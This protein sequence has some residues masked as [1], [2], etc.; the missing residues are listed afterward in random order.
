MIRIGLIPDLRQGRGGPTSF[1]TRFA[2]SLND[3][4]GITYEFGF[5][6]RKF[7]AILLINGTRW[8]HKLFRAKRNGATIVHRLGAP[9][10]SNESANPGLITRL[11]IA[12]GMSNVVFLR[13]YLADHIVYQS[14]FVSNAWV[15]RHGA[16]RIPF[17]IIYNGVDL[18]RFSPGEDQP[19]PEP[20][21]CLI[22]VEGSQS[23]A[24]RNPAVLAARHLVDKG[25]HVEL[26]VFGKTLEG[27][28]AWNHFPFVQSHGYIPDGNLVPFYR[29][30]HVFISTDI[31]NA[32]CPNSVIEALACGTP[33]VGYRLGVLP[34]ILDDKAGMCVP[35]A[36]NPWKG[37]HPG[38]IEHLA[39]AILHVRNH[40]E[41]FRNGARSL[42]ERKFSLSHMVRDYLRI[43]LPDQFS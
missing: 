13:R 32:G 39:D 16:L 41:A 26:Q 29:R 3:L 4:E 14:D 11:R 35:A 18:S 40:M 22:S 20:D 6:S 34:E 25:Y 42:A 21:I 43:L 9:Y 31:K 2:A 19:R 38:S 7:D 36:G 17:N 5:Q 30:A 33:V 27:A 12:I 8:V 37:E 10:S 15:E 24:E 23:D 1:Q 28:D